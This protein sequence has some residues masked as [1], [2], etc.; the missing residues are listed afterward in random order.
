MFGW[1][2]SRRR[3]AIQARPWPAAWS[4]VLSRNVRQ[5]EWLSEDE[6]RRLESW[7]AV[8]LEEKRFEGCRGMR[9]DDEVRVSIAGQAGLVVLGMPGEFLDRLRSVLVYPGDY[10]VPRSTPLAG[11]GELEWR[12]PRL[13]ETRDGGSMV[14]SWPRVVEGGRLRDG[15]RSVVIH[16]CAHVID[17][18]DGE[19]DAVPPLATPAARRDWMARIAGCRERFETALDEGRFVAF[20]DDAAEGAGEFFAVAS[21]C[22]FQDPHRLERY[23]RELYRLMA[24]AWRQDPVTRVPLQRG[25]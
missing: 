10:L 23:D 7:A 4:D 2:R 21:E 8:F 15:P 22:F 3:R 14:L 6:R 1:L 25:R 18:L 24:E 5:V 9:I 12:E 16:E 11:G 20:D 19:I 17:L 13:G